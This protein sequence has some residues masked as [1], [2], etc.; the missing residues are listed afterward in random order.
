MQTKLISVQEEDT[1]LKALI[2]EI[3]NK[4]EDMKKESPLQRMK[5]EKEEA[6]AAEKLKKQ[7][8]IVIAPPPERPNFNDLP[9]KKMQTEL[10][11]KL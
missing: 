10:V 9:I 6:R 3:N 4:I 1:S 8:T 11:P 5:R 7:K 2:D